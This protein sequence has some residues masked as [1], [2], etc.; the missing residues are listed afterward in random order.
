M[1]SLT[2]NPLVTTII[3]TY[4]RPKLLERAICSVLKQTY[5]HFKVCVY[6]NA[7]GDE[8]AA[9]VAEIAKEDSRVKYHCQS[10]NIGA[11]PNF[12]YGM[13]RV[14]TPFYSLLADDCTL[15]PHFFEDALETLN[16]YPEAILFAGQ[17]I[18]VNEKGQKLGGALD[19]WEPGLILPSEGF[20]NIWEKGVPT[21][22]SV[23][24]RRETINGIGLLNPAVGG[25]AD[26][27]FMMRLARNHTFY[28]SKKPYAYYL[29]HKDSW[30]FNRD[31]NE[32]IS[33][34]RKNVEQWLKDDDLS[35][36]IKKRILI[37]WKM[38]VKNAICSHIYVS[39]IIG[40]DTETI[41]T[42]T[43]LMKKEVGYS[44]K[45]VRA[46]IVAKVVNSSKLF[47]SFLPKIIH[48]YLQVK[49]RF[50]FIKNREKYNEIYPYN[51]N[52]C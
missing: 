20:L 41:A 31:L 43:E 14:T 36:T 18:L 17:A 16:R 34:A 33:F 30:S 37:C 25:A 6:D 24:F 12:N 15:L 19:R 45:P 27:E 11:I 10:R 2:S 42:A 5:T 8:T 9:V 3:P 7:S 26:Q 1:D 32:D 35:D 4:R 50:I 44:Y 13:K 51:P 47:R 23:L 22:E 28:I 52:N 29:C 21:W 48:W 38:Y 49:N 39:C 46:I 40:N